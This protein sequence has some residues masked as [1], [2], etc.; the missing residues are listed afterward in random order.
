MMGHH[1]MELSAAGARKPPP[2]PDFSW[3]QQQSRLPDPPKKKK[4][5]KKWNEVEV[6]VMCKWNLHGGSEVEAMR[7]WWYR[8][9]SEEEL[10]E[11]A[12]QRWVYTIGKSPA[13]CGNDTNNR[14]HSIRAVITG[15]ESIIQD[16]SH[17]EQGRGRG[18]R[19]GSR[20]GSGVGGRVS[21]RPE[22]AEIVGIRRKRGKK[23]DIITQHWSGEDL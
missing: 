17:R 9:G 13:A 3:F 23:G 1:S 2:L 12:G 21:E 19:K 4:K 8:G 22:G 7:T 5:K 20:D 18:D 11:H 6:G 14:R 10:V 15:K 16:M